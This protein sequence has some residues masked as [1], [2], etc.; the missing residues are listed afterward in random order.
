LPAEKPEQPQGSVRAE[1]TAESSAPT[2]STNVT[3]VEVSKSERAV[4]Q[5]ASRPSRPTGSASGSNAPVNENGGSNVREK[6]PPQRSRGGQPSRASSKKALGDSTQESGKVN[7]V[8][9]QLDGGDNGP[10]P[11]K[12]VENAEPSSAPAIV[13]GN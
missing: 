5:P 12:S 4:N 9:A 8:K 6:R 2:L 1:R 13:N 7:G 10:A 11:A 3:N